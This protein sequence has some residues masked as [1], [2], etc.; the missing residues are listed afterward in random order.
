MVQCSSSVGVQYHTK[1]FFSKGNLANGM[2]L[3]QNLRGLCYDSPAGARHKL[4]AVP[5]PVTDTFSTIGSAGSSNPSGRADRTTSW[6]CSSA[7]LCSG[8][9]SKLAAFHVMRYRGGS[10]IPRCGVRCLQNLKRPTRCCFFFFF[11]LSFRVCLIEDTTGS[12][13]SVT[14]EGIFQHAP[15]HWAHKI[16]PEV[17]GPD[18]SHPLECMWFTKT[19]H[20]SHLLLSLSNHH[21]AIRVIDQCAAP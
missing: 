5:F 17:S 11:F 19:R 21:D 16:F 14:L 3:L 2:T 1:S 8:L 20:I 12:N 15:D 10:N 6:T 9:C 13:S 4:H 18:Y 7:L